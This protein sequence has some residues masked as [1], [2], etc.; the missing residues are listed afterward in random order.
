MPSKQRNQ[1]INER[2]SSL[3]T[4]DR[5]ELTIRR[6]LALALAEAG[7]CDH[8]GTQT[9]FGQLMQE[10]K[11]G[12]ETALKSF[13]QNSTDSLAFRVNFKGEGSIY[14]GGPYRETLTNICK[15]L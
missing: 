4:G 9:V 14:A 13:K 2:L 15:E 11:K 3:P 12:G 6:R 10:V 8:D 7:G 5:F 1:I